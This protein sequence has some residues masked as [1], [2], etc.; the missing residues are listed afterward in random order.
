VLFQEMHNE[1]DAAA[2]DHPGLAQWRRELAA[3]KSRAREEQSVFD[4]ELFYALQPRERLEQMIARYD[5]AFA[6][7]PSPSGR[8]LG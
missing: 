6:L 8:G 1:L 4:R 7:T 5:G 2:A 3:A